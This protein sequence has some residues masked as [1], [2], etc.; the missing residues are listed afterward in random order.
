MF[1]GLF[2]DAT[3]TMKFVW[4]HRNA[5]VCSTSTTAAT[6]ASGV[7][8]CTSV[9]TGTPI[10]RRTCSRAF[11]PASMP[12]PRK[13]PADDRFALSNDALKMKLMPSVAVMSRNLPATSSTMPS[14][15]MTQGPAIR[16]SGR[17]GPTSKPASFMPWHVRVAARHEIRAPH[18]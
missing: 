16:N 7:S 15:S 18:G 11:N 13:L 4:R 9:S 5:G 12:G 6:S 1:T 8:S 17:S 14:L 3:F 10:C 2:C